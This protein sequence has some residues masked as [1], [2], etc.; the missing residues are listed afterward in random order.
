MLRSG[1]DRKV[2]VP[3]EEIAVAAI[4]L[5]LRICTCRSDGGTRNERLQVR[6]VL[7]LRANA[8]AGWLRLSTL[9]NPSVRADKKRKSNSR[10]TCGASH[11]GVH[12]IKPQAPPRHGHGVVSL[13]SPTPSGFLAPKDI[14]YGRNGIY[15]VCSHACMPMSRAYG[16]AEV[17]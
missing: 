8:K 6:H 5:C 3:V 11:D 16:R 9:F 17:I 13:R 2:Q 12:T 1:V 15:R 14:C 4:V 7:W 10:F